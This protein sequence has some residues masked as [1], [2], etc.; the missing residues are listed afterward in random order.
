MF[1][2]GHRAKIVRNI[3]TIH[4]RLVLFIN[5]FFKLLLHSA[6]V[7]NISFS[8]LTQIS[9]FIIFLPITLDR[10]I[11]KQRVPISYYGSL[12][13]DERGAYNANARLLLQPREALQSKN[14]CRNRHDILSSN[15]F[16]QRPCVGY[17]KARV[18]CPRSR[19]SAAVSRERG[20]NC[21]RRWRAAYESSYAKR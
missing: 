11:R 1:F 13:R 10:T 3:P 9:L 17:H 5:L 4:Y 6:K 18:D 16:I 14:Y 20:L 12:P 15:L 2:A 19:H 8:C 21:S 7:I